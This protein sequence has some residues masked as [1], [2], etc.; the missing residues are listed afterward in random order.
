MSVKHLQ[1]TQINRIPRGIFCRRRLWLVLILGSMMP[2]VAYS[3]IPLSRQELIY[4]HFQRA[5][6][7]MQS[8]SSAL[9]K[10]EFRAILTLDPNNSEAHAKL[11]FVL[12]LQEDWAGAAANLQQ[13]LK[14]QPHLANVQAALGMCEERLG[15]PSEARTLL[16]QAFPHLA[17]G[18]LKTRTGLELAE[19]L[20]ETD[21]LNQVVDIVRTL[22]PANPKNPDVLYTAARTYADLAN[23]FRDALAL[24]EP[25]SGRLHQL[26]AEFLINRGD[27]HAAIIEYRKALESMPTLAGAHLELGEAILLDSHEASALGAAEKQFRAALAENPSDG[28]AEYR[29]GSVYSLRRD[30]KRAIE[31]Y[32]RALQLDPENARAQQELGWAWF[33]LGEPGKA[34]KHLLTATELDPLLPTAHY[35]LGMLYR[36][37]GRAAASRRELTDFER[38]QVSQKQIDQVYLRTRPDPPQGVLTRSSASEK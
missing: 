9:A 35:Q 19:L 7:E 6:A 31:Y 23:R 27:T 8:G 18:A 20:Y 33:R 34:L 21:D 24:A 25:N 12:F 3:Q 5:N 28:S 22:L 11:G 38:L 26:M 16:E 32:S 29:L 10:R 4:S 2:V 37:L 36:K 17:P 15:R 13:A 30:Y 14:T 1:S